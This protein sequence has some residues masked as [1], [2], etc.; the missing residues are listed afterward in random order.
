M[1]FHVIKQNMN[2]RQKGMSVCIEFYIPL[3]IQSDEIDIF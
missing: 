2:F 1:L 3:F